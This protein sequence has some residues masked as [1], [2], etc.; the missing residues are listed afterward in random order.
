MRKTILSLL[1]LFMSTATLMLGSGYLG[2]FMSLRLQAGGTSDVMTGLVMSGFYIG[3]VMGAWLCP[4]VLQRVGHIRAY[5]VFAA[6]NCA[7]V[8]M[9]PLLEYAVIWVVLRVLIGISMMGLSLIVESWLSERAPASIRGRVFSVYMVVTF[10]G[11]GGGQFL[12]NIGDIFEPTH[13]F[14][15]GVL[16]ALCLLPVALTRAMH[17]LPVGRI[18]YNWSRLYKSAPFGFVGALIAGLMNGAFYGLMPVA[19]AKGGLD[20]KAIAGFMAATIF[21]GLLMQ[22]PV[23]M[24]SDRF[25]RRTVL[26]TLTTLVSLL[27]LALMFVPLDRV[28][29]LYAVGASFG[30]LLFTVYPTT[31]AHSHDHFD[32]SQIVTVSSAL[33]LVYGL[34]AGLGPMLAAAAMQPLGGEGLQVFIASVAILY[35]VAAYIR[36]GADDVGVEDQEPYV[37]MPQQ[38]STAIHSMDPRIEEEQVLEMEPDPDDT[39]A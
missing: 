31:V 8:L 24:I 33:L 23:G 18:T 19:L 10:L 39:Q 34:G 30:G 25:D 20:V 4:L 5:A 17:P 3:M 22:Y 14:L 36:R 9:L 11:L 35:G 37:P 21:G 16:F 26:A 38:A 15:M 13:F 27:A 2:T 28:W 6:A 1:A 32:A 29:I 7:A 12:L